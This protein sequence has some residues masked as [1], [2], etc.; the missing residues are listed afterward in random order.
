V[1]LSDDARL[2]VDA[3]ADAVA[4][5]L[6]AGH[7]TSDSLGA[8]LRDLHDRFV[9]KHVYNH[10]GNYDTFYRDDGSTV[11]MIRKQTESVSGG[12]EHESTWDEHTP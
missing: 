6:L 7:T 12:G 8:A 10:P 9:G 2:D 5:E 4:D 3:I 1:T 11:L